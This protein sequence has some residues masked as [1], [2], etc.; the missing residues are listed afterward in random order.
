[1][2][3]C[4]ATRGLARTIAATLW[5]AANGARLGIDTDRL[6]VAAGEST[7]TCTGSLLFTGRHILTAAHCVTDPSD[8]STNDYWFPN[9]QGAPNVPQNG[10]FRLANNWASGGTGSIP[11]GA[12]RSSGLG[13][14]NFRTPEPEAEPEP[15]NEPEHEPSSASR[16]A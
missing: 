9:Y 13:W 8:G 11:G 16:E 15:R 3:S 10:V 7:F 14:A 4:R 12:R 2:F 5:I 6:A 1:M